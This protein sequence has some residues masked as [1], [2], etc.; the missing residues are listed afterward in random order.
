MDEQEK[1]LSG[2]PLLERSS[3]AI[4]ILSF[5]AETGFAFAPKSGTGQAATVRVDATSGHAINSLIRTAPWQF[6]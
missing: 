6:H 2:N 5:M 4:A 1:W 3:T